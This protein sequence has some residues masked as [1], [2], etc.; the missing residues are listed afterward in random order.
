MERKAPTVTSGTRSPRTRIASLPTL[1]G[2]A[3]TLDSDLARCAI[4][5]VCG[6]AEDSDEALHL[7]EM[8]G[9]DTELR[10][11]RAERMPDLPVVRRTTVVNLR[12]RMNDQSYAD[13]VYVG[14]AM[15]SG[16]WHLPR[17][18]FAN[19]F[20]IGAH[21]TREQVVVAYR[22]WLLEQPEL[23]ARVAELRGQRLGCWCAPQACHADVLAELADR[24]SIDQHGM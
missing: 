19:P 15:H 12:G 4:V 2:L 20:H 21:G 18:E 24:G 22:R 1:A 7:I 23:L 9:L 13:V 16:G 17:S 8:L 14:R 5:T 11:M 3:E 6:R 10:E